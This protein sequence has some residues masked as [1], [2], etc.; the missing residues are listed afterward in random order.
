MFTFNHS[1]YYSCSLSTAT[2]EYSTPSVCLCVC[3][4]VRVYTITKK[5]VQSIK[6][7]NIFFYML[8]NHSSVTLF[9]FCVYE[10][11]MNIYILNFILLQSF[12]AEIWTPNSE[13][14]NVHHKS[15]VTILIICVY[16]FNRNKHAKLYLPSTFQTSD[17]ELLSPKI[18][19]YYT[20]D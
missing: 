1:S 16:V 5:M 4:G 12:I 11:L 14:L 3:V 2:I 17:I 20:S 6:L 19:T 13:Y 15:C 18:E 7:D 8:Q 10:C 9:T